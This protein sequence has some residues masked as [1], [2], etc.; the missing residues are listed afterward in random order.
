M[1]YGPKQQF[2]YEEYHN[3]PKGWDLYSILAEYKQLGGER[4]IYP[5]PARISRS[6]WS[7]YQE[8]ISNIADGIR[9]GDPACVELGVRFIEAQ[10]YVSGSGYMRTCIARRLKRASL[11]EEQKQRLSAHFLGLLQNAVALHEYEPYLKLWRIIITSAHLERVRELSNDTTE[12][13][14]KMVKHALRI[15]A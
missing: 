6:P 8:A 13:Q 11:S 15:F 2:S 14:A 9:A 10:V 7:D 5:N 1:G 12:P 4:V 3:S